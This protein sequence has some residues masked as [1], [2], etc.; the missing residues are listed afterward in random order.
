MAGPLIIKSGENQ[1]GAINTLVINGVTVSTGEI[2]IV[3]IAVRYN[4][5][6]VP[7]SADAVKF[8]QAGG[9]WSLN[10]VADSVR[11]NTN[12]NH[13]WW[14]AEDIT[15]VGSLKVVTITWPHFITHAMVVAY[16]AFK[17]TWDPGSLSTKYFKGATADIDNDATVSLPVDYP[18]VDCSGICGHAYSNADSPLMSPGSDWSFSQASNQYSGHL[19]VESV[20][21]T[22]DFQAFYG[23]ADAPSASGALVFGANANVPG[24][25]SLYRSRGR[26]FG[27]SLNPWDRSA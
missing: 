9:N 4:T 7:V 20:P 25:G 2:L 17:A 10:L 18:E 5:D 22:V 3:G 13:E 11:H 12:M 21:Q 8:D 26:P 19:S 16:T 15:L 23:G 24:G 27:R 6:T 14:M 1:G